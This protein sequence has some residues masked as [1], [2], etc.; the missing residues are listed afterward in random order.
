MSKSSV[1]E[2]G[3][4]SDDGDD[5]TAAPPAGEPTGRLTLGGQTWDL[6]YDADD[7]NAVCQIIANSTAIVSGMRTPD[8]NRVDLNATQAA[9]TGAR[10]TYFNDN[11]DPVLAVA[12]DGS[13][14]EPEWGF[15]GSSIRVKGLWFDLNDPSKPEVQGELE[16]TC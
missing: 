6:T 13:S 11:E 9:M 15:D 3:E 1:D 12:A 14:K 10:A 8:G 2:A 4:A 16:V 7:P 5:T